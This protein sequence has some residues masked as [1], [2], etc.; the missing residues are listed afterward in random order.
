MS[1]QRR[2]HHTVASR[3]YEYKIGR[4]LADKFGY[5]HKPRWRQIDGATYR[6]V[7]QTIYCMLGPQAFGAEVR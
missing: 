4:R 2:E 1:R 7:R 3:E 6:T 5:K